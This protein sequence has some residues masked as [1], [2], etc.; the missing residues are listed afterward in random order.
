[1]EIL[2]HAFGKYATN[3]YIVK[4][5]EKSL[6]I[7]P[8]MGASGWVKQNAV[9]AVAVLLTHGHFDHV[10]DADV[11]RR[12]LGVPIYLP[13]ADEIFTAS[14]PFAI[15]RDRFDADFLVSP[16]ESVDISGFKTTFHHFAGHTP[17]CSCIELEGLENTWF[18]GDFI[19][20]GSVGRWDFEFSNAKDMQES[21]RRVLEI[22]QNI[23][24]YCGHGEPTSLDDERANIAHMLNMRLWQE[25]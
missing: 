8:G 3:C 23:K 1:M 15:L 19:F 14:D 25:Y 13:K 9:G 2:S 20:K 21:L 18:C 12:E 17:G 10:Y 24:L 7:D 6:I 16:N 5:N 22:K 11:L 4:N